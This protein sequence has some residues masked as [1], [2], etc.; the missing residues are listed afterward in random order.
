M[1]KFVVEGGQVRC[2]FGQKPCQ[3]Q[4]LSTKG[5]NI[6]GKKI[7]TITDFIPMTCIAGFG[8]CRSPTHPATLATG[9]SP[10]PCTP[11]VMN[12]WTPGAKKTKILG[13]P[14]LPETAKTVCAL[15]MGTLSIGDAKQTKGNTQ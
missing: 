3:L 8:Q 5:K 13:M 4:V 9:V 14:A 12:P 7:A 1:A 6:Q 2:S 11:V 10:Q 15:A